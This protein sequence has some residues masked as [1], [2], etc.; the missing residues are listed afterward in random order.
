[1]LAALMLLVTFA[2]LGGGLDRLVVLESLKS[3]RYRGEYWQ[4]TWRML[5]DRNQ[6]LRWLTGVGP[7]QFRMNYLPHKLPES[8]EEIADPHNA[9]LDHWASG[10]LPGLVAVVGLWGW[11]LWRIGR[12][13]SPPVVQ[14][15]GTIWPEA[16][17]LGLTLA[18]LVVLTPDPQ[19]KIQ[20]VTIGL[21]TL[22]ILPLGR[23]WLD[24]TWT[25]SRASVLLL[26][27]LLHLMFAGGIALPAITQLLLLAA[28][29]VSVGIGT[30]LAR[31]IRPAAHPGPTAS[32][33]ASPVERASASWEAPAE[34]TAGG[35]RELVSLAQPVAAVVGM[36]FIVY[37]GLLPLLRRD[38][39][40]ARGDVALERGQL[41]VAER[42]FRAAATADRWSVLP[43]ERLALLAEQRWQGVP[44]AT[45]SDPTFV[46]AVQRRREVIELQ[47]GLANS[48]RS[49]AELYQ[50]AHAR[51]PQDDRAREVAEQAVAAYREAARR[52]PTQ[53][54]IQAQLAEMLA[55]SDDRSA[56]EEV[57]RQAL[58]L[59]ALNHRLG[60][61]DKQLPA[62][63]LDRLKKLTAPP[64]APE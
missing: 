7:G 33:V 46:Q 9:V 48:W 60:H 13:Q 58:A 11:G 55:A 8:S 59:D 31:Q 52:H 20:G 42:E 44:T 5:T 3:L 50:Q 53:S 57:A 37:V 64:P 41:P 40:L 22:L 63:V 28:L 17:A 23:Q 34:T 19:S 1:V 4:G 30:G 62:D 29:P 45:A 10:G 51:H 26:G 15:P 61:V 32:S 18:G 36:T 16:S 47:P 39:H 14:V 43:R 12:R 25:D 35:G 38:L 49:L 54:R 27:L 56:A 21:L 24:A 2:V 6:P